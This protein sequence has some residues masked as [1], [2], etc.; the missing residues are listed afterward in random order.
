MKQQSIEH[1]VDLEKIHKG[2]KRL[3]KSEKLKKQVEKTRI[4][5]MKTKR[6][7]KVA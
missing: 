4:E 2:F 7:E 5:V 6:D 1:N 3:E